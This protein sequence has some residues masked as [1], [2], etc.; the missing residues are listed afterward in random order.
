MI[1]ANLIREKKLDSDP[2]GIKKKKRICWT[3]KMNN[4]YKNVESKFILK[5]LEK[6]KETRKKF[7]QGSVIVLWIM[8]YYDEVR[9]KLTNTQIKKLKSW[10][11]IIQEQY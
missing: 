8:T 1:A 6:I 5:F 11:K 9:V 10:A 4:N 3:I 2:K 7:S